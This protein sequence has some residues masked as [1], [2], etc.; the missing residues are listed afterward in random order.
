MTSPREGII[1]AYPSWSALV[2][3]LNHLPGKPGGGIFARGIIRVSFGT[4]LIW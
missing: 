1:C 3:K 2:V 4:Q